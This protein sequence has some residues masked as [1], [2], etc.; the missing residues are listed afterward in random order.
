MWA[1]VVHACEWK[2]MLKK[3][4]LQS[5]F[6][7]TPIVIAGCNG[8]S[9]NPSLTAVSTSDETSAVVIS[10]Q[11]SITVPEV[12]GS[13]TETASTGPIVVYTPPPTT[14]EQT[15]TEFL[16]MLETDAKILKSALDA[17]GSTTS[18]TAALKT[19]KEDINGFVTPMSASDREKIEPARNAANK[20]NATDAESVRELLNQMQTLR[21]SW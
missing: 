18:I 11:K 21:K 17:G 13:K 3:H 9:K 15:K 12:S 16:D 7:L 4:L 10:E 6:I 8:D 20:A 14:P 1:F 19:C 2:P 5:F